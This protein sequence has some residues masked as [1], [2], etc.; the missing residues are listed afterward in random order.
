MWEIVKDTLSSSPMFTLAIVLGLGYLFGQINFFGFRFGVAGVLF[1]GLAIGSMG[2]EY[3]LPEIV[4][5]LG[6]AIFVYT[7]GLQSGK[8]FFRNLRQ[9]GY[10]N[11]LLAVIALSVG[12]AAAILVKHLISIP[13]ERAAGM[14][15]GALTSTP[16][17]AAAVERSHSSEPAV[18]Y[19][20]SYPFGIIG[21]LILLQLLHKLWKPEIKPDLIK[22]ILVQNFVITNPEITGKTI[23]D[24]MNLNSDSGFVISRIQHNGVVEVAI[25]SHVLNLNDVVLVTGDEDS[26]KLAEQTFGQP[27]DIQLEL[28]RSRIDYRRIFVSNRALVGS[29]IRDL[30]LEKRFHCSITRVRRGDVDIIPTPDTR[31]DFGDRIRVVADRTHIPE[32]SKYFGDSIRG[33]AELDYGSVGLGIVLGILFGMLPFPIPG[34]G[35]F[36]L[37]IA[38]GT[39]IVALVLGYYERTGPITWLLPMSANLTLRE[40]G[41]ILFLATVGTRAGF[42]F[43]DTLR[44]EGIALLLGGAS[45]TIAATLTSLFVGY[46]LLRIPYDELTGIVAGIQTQPAVLGFANKQCGTERPDVGYTSVFPLATIFKIIAAQLLATL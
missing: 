1:A 28:D 14:L 7:M 13:G 45:I 18:A 36:V 4:S 8:S 44:S 6:L 5:T 33:T 21:V 42:S 26:L 20:V 31:L 11:N 25:P 12:V 46:K 27:S 17:M 37:G 19:S 29:T 39:L 2:T 24:V 35:H 16:A 40:I 22:K 38:G 41:L 23:Q 34:G 43:V 3:A 15:C 32:I 9:R 10:L 30:N